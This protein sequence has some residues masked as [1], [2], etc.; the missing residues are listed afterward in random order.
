MRDDR[1]EPDDE[2]NRRPGDRRITVAGARRMLGMIGRN[3]EDDE[4]LEVLDIFYG[5]AEVSYD[6]YIDQ[7]FDTEEPSEDE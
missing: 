2:A 7:K 1:N 5:M 4:L 6:K 3:Y